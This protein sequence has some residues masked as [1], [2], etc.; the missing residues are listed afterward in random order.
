[1]SPPTA[2]LP[3][4]DNVHEIDTD[5]E[6]KP[7]SVHESVREIEAVGKG[8]DHVRM[9]FVQ[10]VVTFLS[11]S[12]THRLFAHGLHGLLSNTAAPIVSHIPANT[13]MIAHMD[14]LNG[15][16]GWM[17]GI[18]RLPAGSR[19]GSFFACLTV[20]D[21]DNY[22]YVARFCLPNSFRFR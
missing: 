10:I 2:S 16:V 14:G 19:R 9:G 7:L 21:L 4:T 11:S 22:I 20:F 12:S 15:W 5:E 13:K 18:K 17:G 6:S 1:M 8:P 3:V